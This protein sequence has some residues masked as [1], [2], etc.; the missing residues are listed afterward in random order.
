MKPATTSAREAI[1]SA[2]Q[3]AGLPAYAAPMGT[4]PVPSVV[5]EPD[6]PYL[7][8]SSL[9]RNTYRVHLRLSISVPAIDTATSLLAIELLAQ[10][11]LDALPKGCDVQTLTQPA[12]QSIGQAQGSIYA[13]ELVLSAEATKE[14]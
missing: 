12:L 2:L 14:N 7:E 11:I 13:A 5:V 3:A 4:T 8:P 1:A 9:G 6:D 10:E